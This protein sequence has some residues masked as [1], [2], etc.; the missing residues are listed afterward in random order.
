[1]KFFVTADQHFGDDR[2]KIMQRPFDSLEEMHT[3]IITNHNKAVGDTDK[4]FCNGDIVY[5]R[6]YL[7]LIGNLAGKKVLVRGNHDRQFS[8]QELKKYFSEIIDEGDGI[9]L[10]IHDIPY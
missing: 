7:K 9:S 6:K 10:K 5:D 2:F 8:D 4:V 3:T 1:M